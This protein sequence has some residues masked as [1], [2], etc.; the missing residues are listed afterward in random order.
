MDDD[1]GIFIE[2][3]EIGKNFSDKIS[4]ELDSSKTPK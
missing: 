2:K 3:K 4:L 1:N